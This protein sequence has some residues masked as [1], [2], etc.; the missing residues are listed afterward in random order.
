MVANGSNLTGTIDVGLYDSNGNLLFSLGSTARASAS[1]VQ[2]IAATDR[3]FPPG[4]YYLGMVASSTTG[5]YSA[6][7]FANQYEARACGA[8]QEALGSSVLPA[9]MTPASYGQ[10]QCFYFGFTQSDTL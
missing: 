9:T 4:K 6:L 5:T 2:Y 8:L 7:A 1:A 3:S 10:I